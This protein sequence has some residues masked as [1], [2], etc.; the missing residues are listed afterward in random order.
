[1]LLGVSIVYVEPHKK[2][3]NCFQKGTIL[4]SHQQQVNE[5]IA[6]HPWPSVV[7]P[8]FLNS[9][10]LNGLVVVSLS[11]FNLYFLDD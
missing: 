7:L 6:L 11:V 8:V 3:P 4:H 1:M 9:S 2:P 10:H 5:L